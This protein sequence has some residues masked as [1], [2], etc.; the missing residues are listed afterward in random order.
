MLSKI[1]CPRCGGDSANFVHGVCRACYMRAYHQKRAAA[2]VT[3]CPR[4]GVTNANLIKGLCRACYMRNYHQRR[5]AAAVRD[6]QKM[7]E[8]ST[9]IDDRVGQLDDTTGQRLCVECEAPGIYARGRCL[10]CYM[11]DRQR[12]QRQRHCAECGGLGIYARGLCLNCYM[13]DYRRHHRVKLRACAV[14]TAS[15]QS[16]R[17]DALYCSPSCRQKAH[18]VGRPQ[19]FGM[20]THMGERRAARSAIEKQA[21]L[22]PRI[23]V[24]SQA[25]DVDWRQ[26]DS[27]IKGAAKRGRT[28]TILKAERTTL[29]AKGRQIEAEVVPIRHVAGPI[30]AETE[31]E[32]T[33]R[34]LLVLMMMWCD[35]PARAPT[36]AALARNQPQSDAAFPKIPDDVLQVAD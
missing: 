1:E 8:A 34:L 2:A 6:K 21:T 17:R 16:I 31:S 30:G 13:R 20:A 9:L 5:S 7:F 22:A 26:I 25:F 29:S 4:C 19:L 11:R 36:A 10:N 3:Q 28:N 18:R 14:C 27:I 12:R 35:P 33:I 15:F 24:Q 23:E 32:R